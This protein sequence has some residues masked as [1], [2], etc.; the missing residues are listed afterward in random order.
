MVGLTEDNYCC[1]CSGISSFP[2][3][4]RLTIIGGDSNQVVCECFR[5]KTG[6]PSITGRVCSI[7][8]GTLNFYSN[9][10]SQIRL[11]SSNKAQITP[12]I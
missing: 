12:S 6:R 3:Y 8:S 5:F 9:A 11:H 7:S 10:V 2:Q 4:C 1:R